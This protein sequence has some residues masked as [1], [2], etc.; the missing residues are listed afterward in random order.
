MTSTLRLIASMLVLSGCASTED[1][2]GVSISVG[3]N[4]RVYVAA[5]SSRIGVLSS[6]GKLVARLELDYPVGRIAVSPNGRL[7]AVTDLS[8]RELSV[9]V[10]D[11]RTGKETRNALSRAVVVSWL[12]DGSL[13]IMQYQDSRS[14]PL[15]GTIYLGERPMVV[16][17]L[18]P[19]TPYPTRLNN[20]ELYDILLTAHGKIGG[21][22]KNGYRIRNFT[23]GAVSAPI[24]DGGRAIDPDTGKLWILHDPH[25]KLMYSLGYLSKDL[26]TYTEVLSSSR[27]DALV[28]SLRR[29]E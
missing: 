8:S 25:R 11:S 17:G 28:R 4:G 7:L 26:K 22:E 9:R 14:H 21:W 27:F 24:W 20:S 3:P 18:D 23:T 6:S 16:R 12:R 13:L 19:P 29:Q 5:S 1:H 2:Y 15:E 10:L